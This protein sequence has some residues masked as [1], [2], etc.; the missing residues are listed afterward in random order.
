MSQDLQKLA[1][2]V[3]EVLRASSQH[4]VK[5]AKSHAD[6]L[7]VSKQ[8]GHEL[9][10]YKLARRM[11]QRGLSPELDFEQ[12][13]AKLLETPQEKLATY[14]QAVE[15]AASGFRLGSVARDEPLEMGETGGVTDPLDAFIRSNGAYT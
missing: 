4:L 9:Q 8:Q 3:P 11:E 15:L 5:M 12:K 13:V 7:A 1:G 6:L 14:E 2:N 10:A